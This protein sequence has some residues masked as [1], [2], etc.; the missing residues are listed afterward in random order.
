MMAIAYI[1][2]F[3]KIQWMVFDFL[4]SYSV[5]YKNHFQRV[6]GVRT[7]IY[8]VWDMLGQC[9]IFCQKGDLLCL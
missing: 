5:I 3:E 1:Q 2:N 7:E 6:N 4:T 9:I 8:E